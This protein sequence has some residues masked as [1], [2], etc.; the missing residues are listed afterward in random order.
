MLGLNKIM[1]SL[2]KPK[3]ASVPFHSTVKF[4]AGSGPHSAHMNGESAQHSFHPRPGHA[5][6]G[7]KHGIHGDDPD[8][9][10]T[11]EDLGDDSSMEPNY[12]AGHT[13]HYDNSL[14]ESSGGVDPFAVASFGFGEDWENMP[15]DWQLDDYT[16]DLPQAYQPLGPDPYNFPEQVPTLRHPVVHFGADFYHFSTGPAAV[17]GHDHHKHGLKK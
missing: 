12:G 10:P 2:A 17:F 6:R 1:S 15:D 16:D 3:K 7:K 13:G 5:P 14:S 11:A 8:M 9:D 4:H